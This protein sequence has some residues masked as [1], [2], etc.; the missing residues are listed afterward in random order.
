MC[1]SLGVK[2]FVADTRGWG[3]GVMTWNSWVETRKG[4][5]SCV[6]ILKGTLSVEGRFE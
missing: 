3:L 5:Q 2:A 4:A 1:L 6:V